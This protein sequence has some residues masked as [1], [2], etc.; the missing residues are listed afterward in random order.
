MP[1]EEDRRKDII[2]RIITSK[3]IYIV[4]DMLEKTRYSRIP[5]YHRV[6]KFLEL[7]KKDQSE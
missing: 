7:R 3:E 2:R 1:D 4:T 6:W 5:W